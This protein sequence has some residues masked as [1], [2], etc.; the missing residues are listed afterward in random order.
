MS[1][2]EDLVDLS[3][4]CTAI[5]LKLKRA[6]FGKREANVRET[7]KAA[8]SELYRYSPIDRRKFVD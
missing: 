7:T 6:T 2:D 5:C 3:L 8:V 1:N 4:R